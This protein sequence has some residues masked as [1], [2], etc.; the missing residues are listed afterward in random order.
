[1]PPTDSDITLTSTTNSEAEIKA[2]LGVPDEA[3]APAAPEAPPAAAEPAQP[4]P[5][6][7]AAKPA[8]P[9]KPAE[10]AAKPR[11]KAQERIAALVAERNEEARQ[12]RLAEDRALELETRL[13]ASQPPAPTTPE[14]KPEPA[15]APVPTVDLGPEPKEDDFGSFAE[16][17][18][19]L[20]TYNVKKA[21]AE[22]GANKP[23]EQVV[24]DTLEKT[25]QEQKASAE[26]EAAV[27]KFNETIAKAKE[28]HAD[29][30]ARIDEAAPRAPV[31]KWMEDVIL[32][33][34][35]A[36]DI[37]Y[38]FALHPEEAARIA[39]LPQGPAYVEMGKVEARVQAALDAT[40]PSAPAPAAVP[41]PPAPVA[42]AAPPA[43][44]AQ[45]ISQAPAPIAPVGG[46]GGAVGTVPPEEMDYQT[47]KRFREQ[48][49]ARR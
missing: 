44:P 8:T 27:K 34:D 33:S 41:A 43:A 10:P 9:D 11:S 46:S 47:F 6:E 4:A 18:A 12:R 45:P 3:P 19:A 17:N 48:G 16:F 49:G 5:A 20:V 40:A 35:V 25:T 39:S 37:L 2:A 21:L 42:P 31:S 24:K 28:R 30:Q 38:H 1:M 22:S 36:G 23:I 29:Y 7:E 32:R 14:A 13:K 15:P 26:A